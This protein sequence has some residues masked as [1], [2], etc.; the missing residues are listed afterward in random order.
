MRNAAFLSGKLHT[1]FL[2]QEA[3]TL[4]APEPTEEEKIV[5]VLAAAFVDVDFRRIAYEIPE[6]HAS[7]GF[8]RN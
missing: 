8:W 3:G 1:G 2:P 6:P 4:I 5:A 7:I